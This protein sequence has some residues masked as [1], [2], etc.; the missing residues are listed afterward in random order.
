MLKERPAQCLQ[1]EKLRPVRG[2]VL[3][4]WGGCC[5]V[6][7]SCHDNIACGAEATQ[8][9]FL[10]LAEAAGLRPAAH[11]LGF[12]QTFSLWLADSCLQ[13]PWMGQEGTENYKVT[14]LGTEA[15]PLLSYLALFRS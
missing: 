13:C 5:S 2:G 12:R 1:T 8:V 11:L 10:T 14:A 15:S 4:L 3:A 9:Y 7:W 6:S